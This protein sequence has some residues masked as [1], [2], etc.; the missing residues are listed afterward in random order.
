MKARHS[1]LKVNENN[2]PKLVF[3]FFESRVKPHFLIK[4]LGRLTI[5]R[6]NR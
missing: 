2:F 4:R 6:L 5:K 1:K 3:T